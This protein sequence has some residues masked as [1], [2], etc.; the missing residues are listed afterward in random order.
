MWVN[1]FSRL[2]K[3]AFLETAWAAIIMS[4]SLKLMPCASS[5]LHSSP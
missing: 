1:A 5:E 4:K 3:I 2:T